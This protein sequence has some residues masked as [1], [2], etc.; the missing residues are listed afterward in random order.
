MAAFKMKGFGGFGNSPMKKDDKVEKV[1]VEETAYEKAKKAGT[2][3]PNPTWRNIAFKAG[4][5]RA[6]MKDKNGNWVSNPFG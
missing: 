4:F 3:K 6:L 5:S 1:E 2:V